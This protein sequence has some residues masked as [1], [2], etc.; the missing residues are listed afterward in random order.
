MK[1]RIGIAGLLIIVSI[2][3]VIAVVSFSTRSSD[4]P[5]PASPAV[6]AASGSQAA[7]PGDVE[8]AYQKLESDLAALESKARTV[9]ST[10]ERL[11]VLK[12]MDVLLSEFI[13]EYRDS[14]QAAEKS[15]EA[16]MVSFSLQKNK[17]AI[18]YLEGY[19]NNSVDPERDKQAYAHFYLAEAYKQAGEYDDAEAEYKTILASFADIDPRLTNMVNQNMA[20]LESERKLKVGSPPIEFAVTSIDGKKLSPGEFKGKVL[21]LD[22]WATWCG[23]CRQEMPNLIKV[24]EKYNKK[25]FEIVGISLDRSRSDLDRY[26]E[27]ND[28]KWPQYFDGKYY[29]NEVAALYGIMS[30]P[31]TYLIDKKGN[32]RYKSLRGRQLEVAVQELLAE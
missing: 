27:K 31:A 3:A 18:R 2:V 14:P 22:F 10:Q 28:M 29:Q 7:S 19:L 5:G 15:F 30:I 9:R 12:E 11:D 4:S 32:I 26:V 6:A 23:P 25:G 16:G 8:S 17:K 1:N 24:Y 21:L 20:M 13:D